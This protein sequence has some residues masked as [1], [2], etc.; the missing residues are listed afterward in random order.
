NKRRERHQRQEQGVESGHDGGAGDLSIAE[1]LRYVH[2]RERDTGQRVTHYAS[3]TN[4]PDGLEKPQPGAALLELLRRYYV[5]CKWALIALPCC[6]LPLKSVTAL[7]DAAV[8][9]NRRCWY[10]ACRLP[11]QARFVFRF[12]HFLLPFSSH[13]VRS[14]A[15][16]PTSI[17]NE[18]TN[19]VQPVWWLAP[20]PAPV[21][22]LKY[23]WN[24]M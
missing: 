14:L 2:R 5:H 9:E 13:Y 10:A 22:P 11:R 12:S 1:R 23:S 4:R 15:D 21:S 20:R 17:S 19:D 24:G 6:S 3:A 7:H 16:C 18:A 8:G